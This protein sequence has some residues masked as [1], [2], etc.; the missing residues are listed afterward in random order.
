MRTF[1][2]KGILGLA[3]L[4][5]LGTVAAAA[6]TPTP[7]P[8]PA[9][10][11]KTMEEVTDRV[12]KAEG[13]MNTDIRKYS[14]LVETYIQNL[15][16]DTELGYVP[17]GDKYFLGK[18]DFAK[19]VNLVSLS[20]T[21]SKGKKVLG[22]VGN[23]F[24][25]AMQ[26][27]P[28]GFLQMIFI[29]TNGFDKQHYKFDYVK[30]EFLGEVRCLVFDVTPLPKAGK[31]RFLGRIWV[32][33][34]DYHIVRFNGGYGGAG[35]TSYYFHFD[36]W[37]TN[38]QPGIWLPSFVYSEE[39]EL[40]YAMTKKLDFRAQ[41]RLWGY[42]IGKAAQEQELSK[43]LVETPVNDDTKTANDLTPIQAQRSWIAKPRTTFRIACNDWD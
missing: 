1:V 26:Y 8:F 10:Q 39:K 6:A 25:F 23:F 21:D 13:Q 37:R 38:L 7:E 43:I 9:D 29:D 16:P 11:A 35:K 40:H 34:Q 17:A 15:K 32:E 36:S 31:G 3:L 28:D 30:R 22:G 42:N 5:G 12:I 19:G 33:D 27:L 41:T 24:S 4:S 18:A 2:Y 14:P 20:D